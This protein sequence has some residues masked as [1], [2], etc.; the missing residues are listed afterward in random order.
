MRG[1]RGVAL[2]SV[3]WVLAVLSILGLGF[4]LTVR[5]NT[6]LA[7]SAAWDAQALELARSGVEVTLSLIESEKQS[8]KPYCSTSDSWFSYTSEDIGL[9]LDEGI[10]SVQV[11]DEAGKLDI[12]TASQDELTLLLGD[13]TA[14]ASVVDWRDGDDEALA[15]GSETAYYESNRPAYAPRNDRFE[16]IGELALV[17]GFTAEQIWGQQDRRYAERMPG[18]VRGLADLLTIAAIDSIKT[19]TGDKKVNLNTSSDDDLTSALENVIDEQKIQAII[20]YRSQFQDQSGGTPQIPG[21]NGGMPGGVPTEGGNDADMLTRAG[22]VGIRQADMPA[23]AGGDVGGD[24][25]GALGGLTTVGGAGPEG[26]GASEAPDTSL[27]FPATGSLINVPGLDYEDIKTIWDYVTA[28]DDEVIEGRVNI[29]TAPLEVLESIMDPNL[30][31][32]VVTYRESGLPFTSVAELLDVGTD[33]A[34]QFEFLSDRVT[35]R[36]YIF[37]I[38]ATGHIAGT[39]V[40]RRVRETVDVSGTEANVLQLTVY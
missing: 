29:N 1:S 38:E 27:A 15:G 18:E 19:P 40:V 5:V 17:Q 14:S 37:T 34:E 2:I 28:S 32:E 11:V 31:L 8:G 4:S 20:D 39:S 21:M 3:L 25:T 6:E 22:A 30:A 36:S 12:N 10:F 13:E 7:A 16:S 33:M 26:A 23:D 35:V 24:T 9:D